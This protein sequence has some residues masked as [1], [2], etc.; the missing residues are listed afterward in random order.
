MKKSLILLFAFAT[1]ASCSKEETG[2]ASNAAT[3]QQASEI[4]PSLVVAVGRVEPE[5]QIINLS[6]TASGVVKS[7]F[8]NDGD[9]VSEGEPLVQLDD[10]AEQSRINEIKMQMQS[11]RSQIEADQLQLRETQLNFDNK[12]LLLGKTKRLI[13]SGAEAQQVYDDLFTETKVLEVNVQKAKATVDQ[14]KN[15][16]A[17]LNAQLRSAEI[18]AEKKRF[19]SPHAGVL[20]DMQLAKGEATTQFST[21][22]EFA[23]SG[24]LIVRAEVDELFSDRVKPGQKVDIVFTGTDKVVA[25]GEIKLVSP[26]LKKKSLFSES[27]SDQEDRRVRE[28]QIIL[29]NPGTLIINSKVECIIKL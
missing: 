4:Q 3:T 10:D 1:L 6:A 18:E 20:L 23:P 12:N 2:E 28:V 5:N 17:E 14:S 13:D 15:K 21:Y 8:K 24:N 19:K 25:T 11:Q 16:L 27:S 7:V 22:A 29:S 9:N 26:Y